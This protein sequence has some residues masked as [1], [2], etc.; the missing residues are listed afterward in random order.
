[1]MMIRFYIFL[2]QRGLFKTE[3]ITGSKKQK[4]KI[5]YELKYISI[6]TICSLTVFPSISIVL[7][8]KSTPIVLM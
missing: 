5:E 8:L 7:I 6:L 3:L 1:M 4:R 2:F